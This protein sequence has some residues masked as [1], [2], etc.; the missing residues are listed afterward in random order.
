M[1]STTAMRSAI[2]L[3]ALAGSIVAAPQDI[4]FDAVDEA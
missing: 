4:D 2:L 1:F 3:L